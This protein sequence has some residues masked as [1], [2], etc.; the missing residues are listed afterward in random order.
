[1][2]PH[3]R[4]KRDRARRDLAQSAA[5]DLSLDRGDIIAVLEW[6]DNRDRQAHG[7]ETE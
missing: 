7:D 1:M 3:D 5:K 6:L 4:E 2:P